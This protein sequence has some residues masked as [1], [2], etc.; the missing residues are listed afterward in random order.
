MV[1]LFNCEGHSR[2]GVT[3]QV[4]L[5][6]HIPGAPLQLSEVISW[7]VRLTAVTRGHTRQG[8]HDRWVVG[9]MLLH[10]AQ[11]KGELSVLGGGSGAFTVVALSSE[12]GT[13]VSGLRSSP[14]AVH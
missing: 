11:G 2:W 13:L 14:F 10:S 5:F 4:F 8:L 6:L 3:T 7:S 1:V 12:A 9:G